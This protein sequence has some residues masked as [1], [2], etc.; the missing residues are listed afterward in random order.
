MSRTVTLYF[1]DAQAERLERFAR[2]HNADIAE[3]GVRLIDEALRLA[4]HPDIEIRDSAV[5]R[6]AYV[7]GSTLA[8]WEVAMLARERQH[9][10]E[11][12]AAY[13]GWPVAR[14]Q[15]VL[16]YAA[17]YPEEIDTALRENET[18][19]AAALRR[20]LP[21]TQVVDIPMADSS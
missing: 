8:V 19:D 2:D 9:D 21:Q 10:V 7:R 18:F 14:V 11:T 15:A 6:Q 12:T 20:L 5:G 17:A 3:T 1:S 13:L 4:D 16:R